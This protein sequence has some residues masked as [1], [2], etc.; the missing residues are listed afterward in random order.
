MQAPGPTTLF[1]P[2]APTGTTAQVF[3]I[4]PTMLIVLALGLVCIY[5][6]LIHRRRRKL[7]PQELAFRSLSRRMGFSH[8]EANTIRK[9]AMKMGMGSPVGI[10]MNPE[11]TAKA[12]NNL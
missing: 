11:I 10:I 5:L 8:A 3:G 1:S 4:S 9:Y 2:T 12:L 6:A 7:E